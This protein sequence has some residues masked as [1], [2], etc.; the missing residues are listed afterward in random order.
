MRDSGQKPYQKVSIGSIT[1]LGTIADKNSASFGGDMTIINA[2]QK[3]MAYDGATLGRV[4]LPYKLDPHTKQ[5][6]PNFALLK[7]YEA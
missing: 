2:L 5:P 4:T 6:V 7:N 1:E 3:G